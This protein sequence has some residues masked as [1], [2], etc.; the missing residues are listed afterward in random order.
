VMLMPTGTPSVGRA[1]TV[2]ASALAGGPSSKV[3]NGTST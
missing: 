3:E 2:S 1:L